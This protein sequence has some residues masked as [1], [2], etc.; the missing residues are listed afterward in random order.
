M[1]AAVRRA[2]NG[3]AA[4]FEHGFIAAVGCALLVFVVWFVLAAAAELGAL[5]T[6]RATVTFPAAADVL[7][8]LLHPHDPAAGLPVASRAAF[9][10]TPIFWTVAAL[11]FTVLAIP[12]TIALVRLARWATPGNRFEGQATPAAVARATGEAAI[13]RQGARLRPSTNARTVNVAEL[14]VRVGETARNGRPV[15]MG[16]Q[17]NLGLVAG[18]QTGKTTSTMG[19]VPLLFPGPAIM[20]ETHRPD[21][22]A[23][24]ACQ[25]D[26]DRPILILDPE[27]RVGW[28]A[29]VGID[30]LVGCDDHT[31]AHRR[32]NLLIR[33]ATPRSESTSGNMEFFI[34]E[35]TTAAAAFLHAACLGGAGL[36]DV[37]RWAQ[38]WGSQA[39]IEILEAHGGSDE[40][41]SDAEMLRQLYSVDGPQAAGTAGELRNAFGCLANPDVVRTFS[42][43]TGQNIDIATFLQQRGRLYIHGSGRDQQSIAPFTALVITEIVE[44]AL[45]RAATAPQRRLDPPLLLDLDEVANIA[46]LPEL[47][48]YLSAGAGSGICTVWAAQGRAQLRRRWGADA[49]REVWQSTNFRVWFGGSVEADALRELEALSG[50]VW[51]ETISEQGPGWTD[52]LTT[53]R[54]DRH[55]RQRGLHRVPVVTAND[56]RTLP[57]NRAILFARNLPPVELVMRPWWE[58]PDVSTM[59]KESMREFDRMVQR[60]SAS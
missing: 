18:P 39:P 58:R 60:G 36:G 56:L 6:H 32:A 27:N 37:L 16:F 26:F 23:M 38:R 9:P 20:T 4:R 3:P 17:N 46:P 2:P 12:G 30:I 47:P 57:E 48:Y 41:L 31:I 21:V 15:L 7:S 53:D 29:P 49:A 52:A 55:S 33:A 51:E 45:A 43:R 54:R 40:A 42:G 5:A 1:R 13:R 14:G 50:T 28:P 24:S 59:V 8:P 22:M 25:P 11:G 44:E 10:P 35:A 19:V 34:G